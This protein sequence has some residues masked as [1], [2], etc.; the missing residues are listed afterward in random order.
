MAGRDIAISRL[1]GVKGRSES[2]VP[3]GGST[4]EKTVNQE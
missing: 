3:E 2:Q 4:F 1:E